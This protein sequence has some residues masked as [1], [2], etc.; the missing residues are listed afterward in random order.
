MPIKTLSLRYVYHI[1]PKRSSIKFSLS[2]NQLLTSSD[3][4]LPVPLKEWFEEIFE[5]ESDGEKDKEEELEGKKKELEGKENELEEK[6]EKPQP[7]KKEE[8][9]GGGR[10]KNWKKM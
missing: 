5:S 3:D 10:D 7:G 8:L 2:C 4:F 1:S 6:E 9:Q